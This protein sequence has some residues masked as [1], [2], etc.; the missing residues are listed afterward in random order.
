MRG[1]A[2]VACLLFVLG[3]CV[4][5]AQDAGRRESAW[6]A[7]RYIAAG[8]TLA[9]ADEGAGDLQSVSIGYS[10][11][12]K[13]TILMG[14][15]RIHRPTRVR[16]YPDGVTA[17]TR[18]GHHAVRELRGALHARFRTSASFRM[19]SPAEA[20]ASRARTSTT[21]FPIA[22]TNAAYVAF[23]GGGL[24]VPLSSRPARVGRPR[25]LQCSASSDFM[26]LILPVRAGLELRFCDVSAVNAYR[27]GIVSAPQSG[28]PWSRCR[29]GFSAVRR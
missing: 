20:L 28:R 3:S 7:E 15:W 19:R 14:G 2:V 1:F 25:H 9:H 13:L 21:S 11:T 17:F 29:R 12:P 4:L 18:G 22:T 5:D 8:A 23:G 10:P 26:R 16:R 27:H 24:S 6:S